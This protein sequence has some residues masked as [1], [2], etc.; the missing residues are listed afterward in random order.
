MT[1]DY[2]V[3]DMC[4]TSSPLTSVQSLQSNLAATSDVAAETL[5]LEEVGQVPLHYSSQHIADTHAT[6]GSITLVGVASWEV[7][8]PGPLAMSLS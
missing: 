8:P 1:A 5:I 7:N 6:S 2:I 3:D 4:Y